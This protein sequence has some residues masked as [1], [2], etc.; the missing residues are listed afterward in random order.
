[1]PFIA[2][3]APRIR[4][5]LPII[6]GGVSRGISSRNINQAIKD[7]TGKGIKRQT[8]LD[9]IRKIS[10]VQ[11]KHSQLK[12]LNARSIPNINRLP[13]AL[14]KI[15]RRL[16]FRIAVR[17]LL[18]DTGEE[19]IQHVTLTMDNPLSRGAMETM[20]IDL[21]NDAKDRYGLEIQDSTLIS[22][23]RAGTFGTL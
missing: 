8:L 22:G 5:L 13:E 20:A 6:E 17:G 10:G 12:F 18:I 1:M 9:V 23:V 7:A 15:R 14:T 2:T 3:L 19:M 4:A 21:V 11:A 16:S